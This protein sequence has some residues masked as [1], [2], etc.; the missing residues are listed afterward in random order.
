MAFDFDFYLIDEL[1]AAGDQFFRKKSRDYLKE[2]LKKGCYIMVDH[3]LNNLQM[4]CN[5]AFLINK[6]KIIQYKRIF[7]INC[8]TT[9]IRRALSQ[10]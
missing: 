3:N 10:G 4:N 6:N 9:K 5:K 2:K 8:F 7:G 1:S